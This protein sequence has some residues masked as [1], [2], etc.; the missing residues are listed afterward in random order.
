MAS[1]GTLTEQQV[2]LAF[3]CLDKLLASPVF[4][5]SE[6]QCRFLRFLATETL[7]G[8]AEKLKEYAIGI[9]VFDRPLHSILL[10][11]PLCA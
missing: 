3:A 8:H 9:E 6:R 11:R 4:A 1:I 10:P 7:A 5:R 2:S